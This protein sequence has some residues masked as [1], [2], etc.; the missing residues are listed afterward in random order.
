[1]ES[2]RLAGIWVRKRE[3]GDGPPAPVACTESV[4]REA[5]G[6]RIRTAGGVAARSSLIGRL[7]GKIRAIEQAPVSLAAPPVVDTA[8]ALRRPACNASTRGTDTPSSWTF[9]V[10]E[11]DCAL[12][13]GGLDPAGL[14]EVRARTYGDSG[15]TLGFALAL[16]ARRQ[17]TRPEPGSILWVFTERDVREFGTPYGPGLAHFGIDPNRLLMVRVR[18]EGDLAWALE[19]GIKSRALAATFGQGD[20]LSAKLLRRLA[21]AARAC[22]TP[23]LFVSSFRA[24]GF[25]PAL[26]RWRVAAA[27]SAPHPFDRS[28]PGPPRWAVTLE[29][30]RHGPSGRSWVLE[31]QE[32]RRAESPTGKENQEARRAERPTGKQMESVYDAYRF[33][34]ADPLADRAAEMGGGAGAAATAAG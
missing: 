33:R 14:H 4:P 29:R 32:A 12:P 22:R 28:A 1:M 11:I 20:A 17:R 21:L 10:E 25:G 26:T 3:A 9:G 6:P 24:A 31:W 5:Y 23:C 7:R 8:R 19:E 13:G 30:C 16:L 18:R 27:P 34:L 2:K 15:A